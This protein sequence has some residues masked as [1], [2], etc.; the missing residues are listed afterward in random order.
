MNDFYNLIIEPLNTTHDRPNFSCGIEIF[1]NYLQK[2]ATQDIKRHISRVFVAVEK[3]RP[4]EVVGYYTL[5]SLSIELSQLPENLSRKLPKHPVPAVL[6]GRLAVSQ[7]AQGKGVGKMLLADAVKRL[8][9]V[10]DEVAVYALVVDAVN[11]N[12]KRFY[13]RFGFNPLRDDGQRLFLAI[14]SF[15]SGPNSMDIIPIREP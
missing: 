9:S 5:S 1:D 7:F 6:I 13:E 14:K 4:K 2:Q 12:A 8:L 3:D 11:N 15:N 10:S